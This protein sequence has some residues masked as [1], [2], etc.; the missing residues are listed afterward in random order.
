MAAI[1]IVGRSQA[2]TALSP[3]MLNPA[4]DAHL[5]SMSTLETDEHLQVLTSST[6]DPS[7]LNSNSDQ[8]AKEGRRVNEQL[9]VASARDGEALCSAFDAS[10]GMV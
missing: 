4:E 3:K 2:H 7:H 5:K 9:E 6:S 10:P 1:T 8:E